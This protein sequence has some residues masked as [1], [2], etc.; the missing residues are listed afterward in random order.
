M[1]ETLK[2]KLKKKNQ[3]PNGCITL[4]LVWFSV[5]IKILSGCVGGFL[6]F[7]NGE[8]RRC[9][10]LGSGMRAKITNAESFPGL[11]Q[12]WMSELK[13]LRFRI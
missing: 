11:A 4:H 7:G 5:G 3:G 2:T 9:C 10:V 12:V 8:N 13:I 6:C 1:T